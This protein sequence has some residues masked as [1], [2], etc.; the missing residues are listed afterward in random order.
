MDQKY[1]KINNNSNNNNYS[2][3]EIEGIDIN[4]MMLLIHQ[5]IYLDP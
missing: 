4:L 2:N 1:Y 3:Q 5:Q